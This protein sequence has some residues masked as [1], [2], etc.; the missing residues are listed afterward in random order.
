MKRL[1]QFFPPRPGPGEAGDAG[2]F[3]PDSAA[4][5]IARER[6]ILA[7]GP[8]ALL[9][10]VAHP[11]VG[12]GVRSHSGFAAD[13][14]RRL[15]GT[16]DA[17]LTVTFGDR[18]QVRAA[19]GNVALRH[20]PV[21]GTLPDSSG[22]VRAGTPYS[23][24]DPALSLWVFATLVRTA[25]EATEIFLRPISSDERDAYYRDMRQFARLF[26][27]TEEILPA[28]HA[29]L[30]R[31]VAEQIRTVLDVGATARL[32][33]GQL[34][35]PDPPLVALPLRRVPALLAAGLLPPALRDAYALPWRRREQVAFAVVR[36][37]V[38]LAIPMLPARWRYWP[39]YTV[40]RERVAGT[41][42]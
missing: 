20:R 37:V 19:S 30:E 2:L 9:L 6:V 10:Q 38:R 40:A 41:A 36:R 11:L 5:R 23:A 21:Q 27:V 12:E 42:G 4:W 33:G 29:A 32:I 14:L 18:A 17:V 22:S 35:A 31:Y 28:N 26:G 16:L 1:G 3:G 34:L 15:R 13:P 8:A 7:G 24:S 39:H 25:L